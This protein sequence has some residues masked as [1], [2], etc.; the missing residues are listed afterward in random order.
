MEM[1]LSRGLGIVA[2][3]VLILAAGSWY[4]STRPEELDYVAPLDKDNEINSV[5]QRHDDHDLVITTALAL[6]W[7]DTLDTGEAMT[8]LKLRYLFT[9]EGERP[10][11]VQFVHGYLMTP[12]E[13]WD[14]FTH[15][16]NLTDVEA[17]GLVAEQSEGRELE[18]SVINDDSVLVVQVRY[19]YITEVGA[20]EASRDVFLE[21][22]IE[23]SPG[24]T[25][26][27]V[28]GTPVASPVTG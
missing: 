5:F 4:S 14:H 17:F 1:K 20:V 27:S 16:A 11:Q 10:I 8:T 13:S 15:I 7:N 26:V 18:G 2:L 22:P 24:A 6:V 25:P 21:L 9:N 12:G 3:V 23:R 19:G 28:P